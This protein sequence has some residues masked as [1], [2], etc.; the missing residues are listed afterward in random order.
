MT[1]ARFIGLGSILLAALACGGCPP[2]PSTSDTLPASSSEPGTIALVAEAPA[3]AAKGQSVSLSVALPDGMAP[4][5][6]FYEW[7]QTYGTVV[8]LIDASTAAASF[9]AP[10]LRADQVLRFRVD[11]RESNGKISSRVVEVT[12]AADQGFV[13]PTTTGGVSGVTGNDPFPRVRI[14]TGRGIIIVRL[15]RTKA[16]ISVDN[17]L[18]Y[19]DDK[20]YDGTIFHRVIADFVVQGG[21][22]DQDLVQKEVRPSIK[23]EASNGLKNTRGTIAMARTNDPDSATSQF[24]FNLVDNDSLDARTDFPGYAVFGEIIEGIETID[25]IAEEE[26][27]TQNGM[28]DVP[29]TTVIIVAAE[30]VE[31]EG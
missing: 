25:R 18:R 16:P 15:D 20:F 17:F 27:S 22:F 19:V 28:S 26:T 31:D 29:V 12:I 24:Y 4:T 9:V 11:V 3:D 10:S 1:T 30:R 2:E 14:V 5:E 7:Y 8:D 23:N 6:V 13:E 21:G